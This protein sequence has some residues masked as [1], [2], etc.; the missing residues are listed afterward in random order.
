MT[1][2]TTILWFTLLQILFAAICVS[3]PADLPGSLG[4]L[5]FTTRLEGSEA[6]SFLDR[7]HDKQIAPTNSVIGN[8]RQGK[9]QASIYVST[10]ASQSLAASAAKQMDS[11]ISRRNR[12]FSRYSQFTLGAAKIGRC[13]GMGLTHFFFRHLNQVYWM[14]SDPPRSDAALKALLDF[15]A[16]V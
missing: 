7:L 10:F 3:Q 12:V 14:S 2:N 11:L 1:R 15:L 4:S 16:K 13:E 8:Y 6:Q 5:K 9:A